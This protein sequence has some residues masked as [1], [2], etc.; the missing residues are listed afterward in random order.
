MNSNELLR[1]VAETMQSPPENF[2]VQRQCVAATVRRVGLAELN[3][4]FSNHPPFE[5][6]KQGWR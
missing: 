4:G 5:A 1:P 6:C 2:F 3:A